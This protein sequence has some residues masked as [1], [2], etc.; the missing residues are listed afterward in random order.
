M[1]IMNHEALLQAEIEYR[2][3]VLLDQAGMDRIARE[4]RARKSARSS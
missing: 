4:I 1:L 2:R 3:Q